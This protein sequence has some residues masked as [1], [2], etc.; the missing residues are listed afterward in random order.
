[1]PKTNNAGSLEV[2]EGTKAFNANAVERMLG[3]TMLTKAT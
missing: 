2:K 1:M 3:R